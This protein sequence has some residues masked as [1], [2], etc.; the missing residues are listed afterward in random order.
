MALFGTAATLTLGLC[1]L[2]DYYTLLDSYS[3]RA[4][5][6]LYH[7]ATR[8]D[9]RSDQQAYDA[10]QA[11]PKAYNCVRPARPPAV[12]VAVRHRLRPGRRR[13]QPVRWS[14]SPAW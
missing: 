12:G 8:L 14:C 9:A 4:V 5:R 2:I 10:A 7:P 13:H 1:R 3:D 6:S 11:V